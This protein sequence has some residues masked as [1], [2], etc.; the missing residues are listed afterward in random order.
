MPDS[1]L[2]TPTR[3]S[4]VFMRNKTYQFTDKLYNTGLCPGVVGPERVL[5]MDQIEMLKIEPFDHLT[6]CK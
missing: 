6:V 1:E 3:V 2:P 5:S 4:N